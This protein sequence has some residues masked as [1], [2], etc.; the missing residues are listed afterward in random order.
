M[1]LFIVLSLI[2][3][4]A[5]VSGDCHNE[6]STLNDFDWNRVGIG[7]LTCLLLRAAVKLILGFI[8]YLWSHLRNL[9]TVYQTAYSSNKIIH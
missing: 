8:Y 2:A 5:L 6:T 9:N 3:K 1:L 7:V 4:L